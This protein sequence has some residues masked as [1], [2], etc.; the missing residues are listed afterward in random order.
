MFIP[1][2]GPD[3]L[4]IPDPGSYDDI[5]APKE[6][7]ETNTFVLPFCSYKYHKIVNNFIFEQIKFFF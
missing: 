5:T 7:G 3:I 6:E 2:P 1:A 4:S